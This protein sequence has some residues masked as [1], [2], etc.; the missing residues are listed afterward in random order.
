MI[1]A[2]FFTTTLL[3]TIGYGNLCL[4]Q[5]LSNVLHLLCPVRVPLILITVA[6]IAIFVRKIIWLYSMYTQAKSD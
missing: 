5:L 4:S 6:D 3:T 1:T 2:I